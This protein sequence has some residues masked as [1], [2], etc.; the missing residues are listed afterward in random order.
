MDTNKNNESNICAGCN[1]S[2]IEIQI[3]DC[4]SNI[5]NYPIDYNTFP[6]AKNCQIHKIEL[7]KNQYLFMP[8]NWFH[9]IY[10]EPNTLSVHYKIYNINFIDNNNNFYNSL[11]Y[12]K[13]FFKAFNSKYN[14]KHM[15]FINKSL[16]H[17]YRAIFSETDDCIPVQKDQTKKFFHL[18]NLANI[19]DINFTNN[20]HTYVGN[21][22]IDPDNIMNNFG[23]IN[24]IIDND[25]HNGIHYDP[26]VW[27]T[28]DK[29]VN[30]GLHCDT[31]PNL[32]YMVDGKKTIYLF[33]PSCY[34]N[35]YIKEYPLI[36]TI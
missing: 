28:L 17:S 9:W 27:F 10:T 22:K 15:D 12:S 20:Y 26:S 7:Y 25:Y 29:R 1:K 16:N 6:L 24:D 5:T 13:P 3:N 30:S 34:H 11:K 19:I 36:K 2:L 31:T 14:I 23:F 18:D 35:L 33:S 8:K 4:H 21:N 32:I